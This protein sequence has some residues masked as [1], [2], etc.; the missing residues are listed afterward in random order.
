MILVGNYITDISCEN[1][2]PSPGAERIATNQVPQPSFRV[3]ACLFKLVSGVSRSAAL[4][5]LEGYAVQLR[6]TCE[7]RGADTWYV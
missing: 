5:E 1:I 2:K 3:D 7:V 6:N 4:L